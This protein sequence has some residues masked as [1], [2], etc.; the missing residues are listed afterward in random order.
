MKITGEVRRGGEPVI[1]VRVRGPSGAAM[2]IDA[3]VDTGF[4]SELTMQGHLIERLG[5]TALDHS[6]FT[7]ADGTEVVARQYGLEV[8]LFGAWVPM[9]AASMEGGPLVGMEFLGGCRLEIDA[10]PGGAVEVALLKR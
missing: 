9:L 10:V 3:V 8:E 4:S 5:L 1:P 7:L 2:V 6:L